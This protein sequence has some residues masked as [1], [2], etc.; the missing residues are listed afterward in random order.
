[1]TILKTLA[2]AAGRL[3]IVLMAVVTLAGCGG[4]QSAA[5]SSPN[6][7]AGSDQTDAVPPSSAPPSDPDSNDPL[8]FGDAENVAVVTIGDDRY[9]F[10]DLYCVS[11]GGAMGATSAGGDPQVSID[12]PPLDWETSN[13]EWDAPSIRV[14]GDDPYF[15]MQAGG[16]TMAADE[17]VDPGS[18]QV[19]SFESDGYHAKGEATFIDAT[20]VVVSED[21]EPVTGTFE[22]TCARP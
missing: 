11:M 5:P 14:S 19:D 4:P 20:A 3:A 7:D 6:E 1:M 21:P 17:R 15:D 12:L 2:N 10:S 13:E 22:V 8:G 18:S 16:D 9:E